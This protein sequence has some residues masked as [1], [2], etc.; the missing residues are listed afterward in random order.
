M[1]KIFLIL[2]CFF[3][4]VGC[5]NGEDWPDNKFTKQIP[6]PTLGN[7]EKINDFESSI[8]IDIENLSQDDFK[9]YI[10]QCKKIGFNYITEESKNNFTA[11]NKENYKLDLFFYDEKLRIMVDEPIE[12]EAV[13]WPKNEASILL[14]TPKFKKGNIDWEH[15]DSFFIH[16]G[17][18][19]KTDFS[20]YIDACKKQGFDVDYSKGKDY[21]YADN[22]DSSYHLS[23]YYQLH[24]AD[25]L[26]LKIE[27]KSSNSSTSN[28]E[29]N[30]K[31]KDSS[32]SE[33]E[34]FENEKKD[35]AESEKVKSV[36]YST[37]DRETAK[38]G[39]TGVFSYKDG[40]GAYD[41]YWIIDFDERYVYSFTEGNGDDSYSRLKMDF[42]TLN[43]ALVFTWHSGGEEWSDKLHFKYKS[44]P[45]TLI[46]NDANGFDFEYETTNLKDALKIR[47]SKTVKDY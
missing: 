43:D 47:D 26:T 13:E 33:K 44:Q 41:I 30:S 2:I 38:N 31:S 1:K 18:F 3:M 15:S 16:L 32:I 20:N 25:I 5:G 12:L 39:N 9:E 24:G 45:E 36:S 14:P 7:I 8:I 46:L 22:K 42:G 34:S 28:E 35:V 29:E 27:K 23:L 10:K 40:S 6:E 4:L 37:N 17:G 11:F 21:Y 19:S